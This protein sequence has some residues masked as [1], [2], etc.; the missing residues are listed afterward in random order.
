MNFAVILAVNT[1]SIAAHAWPQWRD[2][3]VGLLF[4]AAQDPA[5]RKTDALIRGYIGHLAATLS[6]GGHRLIAFVG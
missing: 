4:M 3:Q 2:H 6:I 1:T 5:V